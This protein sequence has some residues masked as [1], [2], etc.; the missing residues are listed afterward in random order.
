[1]GSGKTSSTISYINAHPEKR[2]IYITPYLPEAERIS[3]GCPAANFVEPSKKLPQY[4]FSKSA[5]TLALIKEG[6]NIASTHQAMLYYTDETIA[7]LREQNYTVIIDEDVEVFQKDTAIYHGD[8]E[9]AK[10]AGYIYEVAPNK[11]EL[12][13]KADSYK[14]GKFSHM[15]RVMKSRNLICMK[16][17]KK[18]A[19]H[20]WIFPK[21]LFTNVNEVIILTYLFNRSEMD[22][23]FHMNGIEYTYIGIQRTPDNGYTFADHP[24]YVP[25]YVSRLDEMIIIETGERINSIGDKKTA[26]SMSWF[27]TAKEEQ[28]DQVR[29]NLCNYFRFRVGRGTPSERMCGTYKKYWGRI[30]AKGFWNSDVVFS[31]KSSNEFRNRTVLAYP[32]NLFVNGDTV[33]FY[34]EHG[35]SFDNDRYALSIMLQWI[36]RSAIRDGKPIS[37]YIP[38]RRMRELLINWIQHMKG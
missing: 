26:L 24:D 30:R 16:K 15:F 36:W 3:N 12:T 21:E 35:E 5:H 7:A 17:G 11:F 2:F 20:Y 22:M 37:I 19:A 29:K 31:Q 8:V 33:H 10:E 9:L 18:F 14:G 38:S 4:G 1:M 28:I 34:A 13:D 32:V 6:R 27:Q 25:E 23:F